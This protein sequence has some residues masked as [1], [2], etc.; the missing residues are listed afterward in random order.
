M[1]GNWTQNLTEEQ[2]AQHAEYE[3]EDRRI[4]RIATLDQDYFY[5]Q[6]LIRI[7]IRNAARAGAVRG[8]RRGAWGR[9]VRCVLCL[10]AGL[11]GYNNETGAEAKRDAYYT[12]GKHLEEFHPEHV[13]M[14]ISS[15][16]AALAQDREARKAAKLAQA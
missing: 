16:K 15:H 7:S 14:L 6:Q 9:N 11:I 12:A 2:L 1:A 5:G 3:R 4:R 10:D 13:E 8:I